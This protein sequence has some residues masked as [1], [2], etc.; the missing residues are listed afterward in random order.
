MILPK[1]PVEKIIRSA[2]AER[3]S[4]SASLEL[5]NIL[6]KVGSEIAQQAKIYASHAG[7]KTIIGED[8]KLAYEQ[9]YGKK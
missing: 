9:L 8:I 5:L 3:V 4:D 1:A 2:G 7:R 6:D